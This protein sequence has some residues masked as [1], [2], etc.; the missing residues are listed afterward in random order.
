ML[1]DLPTP[2]ATVLFEAERCLKVLE[3]LDGNGRLT[4]LGKAMAQYPM[5][6]RHSRMLLTVI[7]IMRKV[8]ICTRANLVL[9]YTLA[10]AAALSLPNPFVMQF[11]GSHTDIDDLKQDE[12]G[13]ITDGKKSTEKEEKLR[14]KSAKVSL[15]KFSDPN[16][17][18]LTIAYALQC[19]GVKCCMLEV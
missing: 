6:P 7:Q 2:E 8:K 19:F 17:D 3:A 12:S 13:G 4:S 1:S 18:T 11:E 16:S 9:G 10:A 15:A 5:S 14:R